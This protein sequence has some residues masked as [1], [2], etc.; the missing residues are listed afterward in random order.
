MEFDNTTPAS[1]PEIRMIPIA[2]ITVVNPRVRNKKKFQQMTQNIADV[3][4]KKPITVR[5]CDDGRYELVCGHRRV[6]AA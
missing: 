6:A 5:P 3:G 2:Q 4:L 1:P